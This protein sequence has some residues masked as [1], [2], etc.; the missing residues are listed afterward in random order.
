MWVKQCH[1]PSPSHQHFYRRYVY[2]Y[3]NADD[4]GRVYDMVYDIVLPTLVR[5]EKMK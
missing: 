1:K 3:K 4:W 2:A 5:R